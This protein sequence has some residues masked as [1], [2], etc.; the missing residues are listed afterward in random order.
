MSSKPKKVGTTD[1]HVLYQQA[2]QDVESEIDFVEDTF[3]ELRG[4]P[5]RSLRED[6]CGTANT[7]TEWVKRSGKNTAL[8]VDLDTEVLAWGRKHN[9]GV[10]KSSQQQ[11]LKLREGDVRDGSDPVDA[12]LAMNFSYFLFL[13]RDEMRRYFETVRASLVDDGVFFMDAYGGYDAPREIVEPRDC[14]DFT[15]IWEQASFNPINSQMQCYIHFEL[16]DGT[17][18]DRAFTYYWRLWTLPELR[19]LLSEAG[20]SRTRVYWEGTD[21]KTNEGN[22]IFEETE[23][24]DADPGWICYLTAEI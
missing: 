14:G 17:R 15:Y 23:Q 10:L 2:V 19:E 12:V 1:R 21:E 24:G 6:F 20:F 16:A 8:A 18:L 4:R 9:R 13:E 11:R 7:A 22:G 3:R 5:A